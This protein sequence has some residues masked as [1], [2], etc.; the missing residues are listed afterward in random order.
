MLEFFYKVRPW[1]LHWCLPIVLTAVLPNCLWLPRP[2]IVP[3]SNYLPKTN[4][5]ANTDTTIKWS[6][7][8]CFTKFFI[9]YC[10]YT[11]STNSVFKTN[12]N[13]LQYFNN[14]MITFYFKQCFHKQMISSWILYSVST[15]PF[16][17]SFIS[18]IRW[19]DVIV[20]CKVPDLDALPGSIFRNVLQ[21]CQL[22]V[23]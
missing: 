21:A 13:I 23:Y 4:K 16:R 15:A 14:Q 2:Y 5:N 8:Q 20:L 19:R 22:Q 9:A 7:L 6:F 11:I 3:S 10:F 12:D 17:R 1:P 18:A